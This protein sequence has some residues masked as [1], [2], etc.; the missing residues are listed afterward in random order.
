MDEFRHRRPDPRRAGPGPHTSAV[1]AVALPSL[2][3]GR[4]VTSEDVRSLDDRRLIDV[5]LVGDGPAWRATSSS[6][7]ARRLNSSFEV[8]GTCGTGPSQWPLDRE[9]NSMTATTAANDSADDVRLPLCTLSAEALETVLGIRAE[10]PDPEALGL[11]IEIVGERGNR[12]RLRPQLRRDRGRS[13]R[14]RDR[15]RPT[16]SPS[17]FLRSTVDRLRGSVLD[18]A[19]TGGGLVIR[20]PHRPDPLAGLDLEPS[21]GDR[22]REDRAAPRGRPSTRHSRPTADSPPWSGWRTNR[23]P[24]SRWA[25]AARAAR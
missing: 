24:T 12:L 1:S 16:G 2:S 22:R 21:T 17:S 10:E 20:N 18:V 8:V 3:V 6:T 5:S 11:R 25:A 13:G 7:Q 4:V 15:G 19:R 23:S 14:R 9:V